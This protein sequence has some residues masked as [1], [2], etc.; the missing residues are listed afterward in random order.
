V[1]L[2]PHLIIPE[3]HVRIGKAMLFSHFLQLI[4]PGLY[5]LECLIRSKSGAL[6]SFL[7]GYPSNRES[8]KAEYQITLA[9]GLLSLVLVN[10]T[11]YQVLLCHGASRITRLQLSGSWVTRKSAV[12]RILSNVD[13]DARSTRFLI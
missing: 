10:Y 4:Q 12:P 5:I 13:H 1:R 6:R 7:Y 2:S 3:N 9:I 11:C 8:R